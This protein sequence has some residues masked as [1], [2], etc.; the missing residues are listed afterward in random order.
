MDNFDLRKYLA[1]SKLLKEEPQSSTDNLDVDD[2]N[3]DKIED[4]VKSELDKNPE[5]RKLAL[6]AIKSLHKDTGL[7]LD[8]MK[9]RENILKELVSLN[10]NSIDQLSKATATLLTT[11]SASSGAIGAAMKIAGSG[12]SHANITLTLAALGA[13]IAAYFWNYSKRVDKK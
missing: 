10:E 1:E 13:G 8:D 7:S 2:P 4:K 3:L 6:K 9:D 5:L 11:L 12:G